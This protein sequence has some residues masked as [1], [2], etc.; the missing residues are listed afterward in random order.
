MCSDLLLGDRLRWGASRA[1]GCR[2]MDWFAACRHEPP[3]LGAVLARD[4]HRPPHLGQPLQQIKRGPDVDLKRLRQRPRLLGST[5]AIRKPSS[6]FTAFRRAPTLN[7][8]LLAASGPWVGVT[9]ASSSS[10]T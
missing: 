8:G 3:T 6:R 4:Y 10:C 9:F 1:L 2:D 7:C 5:S